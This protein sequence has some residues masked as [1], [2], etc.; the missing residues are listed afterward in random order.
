M[1]ALDTA[2]RQ[3]EF[4][5]LR[6]GIELPESE[7]ARSRSGAPGTEVVAFLGLGRMGTPMAGRLVEAGYTV[8]AFDLSAEARKRAAA[9]GCQIATD[10]AGAVVGAATVITMLPDERAVE[11][12][13]H[14]DGGLLDA[15]EGDRLWIEMTSSMPAVTRAIAA[16]VVERGG[17]FLDAPVSGGVRGAEAGTLTVMAAGVEDAL[18]EARPILEPLSSRVVYLGERPGAGDVAKS[19]N[20]MLSAVNLTA[21]GEALAIAIKEG[22]DLRLLVDAI[23]TS[24]G[25]SDAMKVKVGEFALK[26][27]YDTGFT[28]GQ[29]LK[30]LRIALTMAEDDELSPALAATTRKLW[31]GLAETEGVAHDHTEVVPMLLRR[32][33]LE[34]PTGTAA[35]R[36]D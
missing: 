16:E 9:V 5:D 22:V 34:L 20:N 35:A 11:G 31:E 33:G 30:D 19:V 12:L 28:I 10:V 27:R 15:W 23:G 17:R 13:A 7:G 6:E 18:A 36:A 24:T 26:D 29:Y 32:Q 21:A 8:S 25:A 1:G 3:P 2:P 14:G 4:V